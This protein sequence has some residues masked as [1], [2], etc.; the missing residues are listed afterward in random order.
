MA[1]ETSARGSRPA[2][3]V[4]RIRRTADFRRVLDNGRRVAGRWVLLC[5][6]AT[7]DPDGGAPAGGL[8][9][10]SRA[11]WVSGRRIGNAV[12]RNR[13]RRLLREAWRRV[14][15]E[16][17]DGYDLVMVALP[18]IGE[19]GLADVLADVRGCLRRAGVLG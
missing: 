15:D 18:G 17:Q 14:A 7:V 13:G 12:A 5:S 6:L 19:A 10:S 8:M 1:V 16:V 2:P 4:T 3:R 11:G 9:P